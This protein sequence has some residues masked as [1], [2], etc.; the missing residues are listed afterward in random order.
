[1]GPVYR[2]SVS[3]I[4]DPHIHLWDQRGTPRL[5][6][7][8]VKL[9]GWNRAL[10][11]WTAN[12]AFPKDLIGFFGRP[13][14]V[15]SDYLQADYRADTGG[16]NLVGTVHVQAGWE[17]KGPLGPV[18]ETRW[19]DGLDMPELVGIVGHADLALGDGVEPA[20]AAHV[21]ASGRFRGIRYTLANSPDKAVASFNPIA[22]QSRDPAFRKGYAL[23]G[24][25]NLRFDAWCYHHQLGEVYEL[26][27][28]HPEVPVVLCHLGTPVGWVGNAEVDAAWRAD[29]TRL[30]EL[31]NVHAKISGLTMPVVG[32]GFHAQKTPPDGAQLAQGLG[33]LV[34]FTLDTFGA[35]RCMFASNFPVDKV[36][37]SWSAL[38]DAYEALTEGASEDERRALFHDT[39]G[40]FYAL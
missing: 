22:E 3:P 4:L 33:P 1:M 14:M 9:L 21:E 40:R 11:M 25:Y 2:P 31:P 38:Y 23:L 16:R 10:L 5:T 28:A 24:K 15:M 20:L 30:A 12:L 8:V 27:A 26:A 17:E 34:R 7:P 37:C 6:S 39:A 19:L 36:S 32:F 18:G 35:D 13:D 29:M